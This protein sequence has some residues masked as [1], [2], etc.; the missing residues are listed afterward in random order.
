M[1]IIYKDYEDKAKEI[2]KHYSFNNINLKYDGI[3]AQ[4][5][6]EFKDRLEEISKEEER[7]NVEIKNDCQYLEDFKI[8]SEYLSN[9]HIKA[10]ACENFLKQ[11]V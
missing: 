1:L 2:F 11:K 9:K 8:V 4:V 7:I 6:K 5:V 10:S 3:P